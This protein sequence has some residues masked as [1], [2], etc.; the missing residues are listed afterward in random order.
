LL[1][2]GVVAIASW[3]Q[4]GYTK[5]YTEYA[6]QQLKA[7]NDGSK[8]TQRLLTLYKQQADAA[9]RQAAA[10]EKN[11][12]NSA[13]IASASK[14]SADI[15]AVALEQSER[16]WVVPVEVNLSPFVVGQPAEVNYVL[17]NTG[18]SPAVNVKARQGFAVTE[19]PL[20]EIVELVK[21]FNLTSDGML[22]TT[23][24]VNQKSQIVLKDD[25][26]KAINDGSLRVFV[27]GILEYDTFGKH[28]VN[29]FCFTYSARTHNQKMIYCLDHNHDN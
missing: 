24:P 18:K 4:A 6:K 15:A 22:A 19:R 7:I 14:K 26:I 3:K 5:D 29:E 8:D 27:Y 17:Y 2:T 21:G 13:T 28:H 23:S 20:E 1:F 10:L 11:L 16:A 25:S 9:D 12:S